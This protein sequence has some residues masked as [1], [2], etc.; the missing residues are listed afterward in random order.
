MVGKTIY[1]VID[2]ILKHQQDA[3]DKFMD[4]EAKM[5]NWK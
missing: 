4:L 3:D 5:M 2:E 1:G